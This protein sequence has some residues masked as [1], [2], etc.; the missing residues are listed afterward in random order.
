MACGSGWDSYAWWYAWRLTLRATEHTVHAMHLSP[1]PPTT[2][3]PRCPFSRALM[4]DAHCRL[5]SA[6]STDG[7][8]CRSCALQPG[9]RGGGKGEGQEVKERGQ[10]QGAGCWN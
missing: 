8:P 2:V 10:Q 7:L 9:R 6:F 3:S 5:R 4:S 1:L